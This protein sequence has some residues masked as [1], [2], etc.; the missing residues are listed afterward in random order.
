MTKTCVIKTLNISFEF[1]L[2]S[3]N[4][5]YITGIKSDKLMA[6]ENITL[7]LDTKKSKSI[8][9]KIELDKWEQPDVDIAFVRTDVVVSY[10]VVE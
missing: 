1:R 4:G 7:R 3:E 2:Y 9:H 6:E 8:N 10:D 5:Q